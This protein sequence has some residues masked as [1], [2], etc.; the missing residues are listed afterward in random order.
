M[1]KFSFFI[2]ILIKCNR[3]KVL[4]DTYRYIILDLDIFVLTIVCIFFK[5]NVQSCQF[6]RVLE[7]DALNKYIMLQTHKVIV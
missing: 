6:Q 7:R 3:M 1:I 2:F 5:A 4:L